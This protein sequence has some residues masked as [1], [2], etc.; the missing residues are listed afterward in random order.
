MYF[1]IFVP[2]CLSVCPSVQGLGKPENELMVAAGTYGCFE[3][4]G[5]FTSPLQKEVKRCQYNRQ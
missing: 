5:L 2:V 1:A 3:L 4:T